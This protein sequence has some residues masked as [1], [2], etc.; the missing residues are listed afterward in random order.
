[1][2]LIYLDSFFIYLKKNYLFFHSYNQLFFIYLF[3]YNSSLSS[4]TQKFLDRIFVT[5]VS[6]W[7]WMISS[8][9]NLH[10]LVHE[11]VGVQAG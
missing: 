7:V 1:M 8:W 11:P 3:I 2:I 10:A 5:S 6:C 4:F 9:A